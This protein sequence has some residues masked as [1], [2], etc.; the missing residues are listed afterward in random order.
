MVKTPAERT[1]DMPACSMKP[2]AMLFLSMSRSAPGNYRQAY[3]M[4]HHALALRRIIIAHV[5]SA[6]RPRRCANTNLDIFCT[7]PAAHYLEQV[8]FFAA[9]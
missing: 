6:L 8:A 7:L 9:L 5:T 2:I 4:A 1:R 3:S